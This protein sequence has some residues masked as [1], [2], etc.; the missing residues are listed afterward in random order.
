MLGLAALHAWH[1]IWGPLA[2]HGAQPAL[3][4]CADKIQ[5]LFKYLNK[6]INAAY[7]T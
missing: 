5:S 6:C 4:L 3:E 1:I 7:T 2:S